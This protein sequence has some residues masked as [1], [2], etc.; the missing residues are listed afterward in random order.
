MKKKLFKKINIH[1]YFITYIIMSS[2]NKSLGKLR[3]FLAKHRVKS[4]VKHTNTSMGKLKGSYSIPDEKYEKF[5]DIYAEAILDGNILSLIEKHSI[6]SPIIIDLDFRHDYN[7]GETISREFTE[8]DIK[9][10][11]KLYYEEIRKIFIIDEPKQLI[12]CVFQRAKPYV[13]DT[14]KRDGVHIMFPYI[15]SEPNAQFYLRNN[16]LSNL[17]DELDGLKLKNNKFD[18]IDRCVIESNGWFLYRSTKPKLGPYEWVHTY[19]MNLMEIEKTELDFQGIS[20]MAKFFSIRR[21]KRSTKVNESVIE[22]ILKISKKKTE[23]KLIKKTNTLTNYN[24][25][26]I[27]EYINILAKERADSYTSWMEVGWALH[28]I[29]PNDIQLLNYWIEFS[30]KSKKF[31]NGECETEWTK[32]KIKDDG[33]TVASIYYWAK[34]DNTDEYKKIKHKDIHYWVQQSYNSTHYGVAKVLHVMFE[35]SFVCVHAKKNTWYEFKNHKWNISES[36]VGLRKKIPTDLTM[37][38]CRYIDYL[39]HILVEDDLTAEEREELEDRRDK[40]TQITTRL[41]NT[42]FKESVMKECSADLFHS[43]KFE[44]KLDE[45]PYLIGFNNGVYDL[46]THEFRD[47]KPDDFISMSTTNDYIP[48]D[49]SSKYYE[50]IFDF[51]KKIQPDPE[52]REYLLLELASTLEGVNKREKFRVWTGTGGNGKSKL[53]ELFLTTFG[54][55]CDKFNISLLTG[56]RAKSNGATPDIVDSKGKRFAYLEEPNEGAKINCGLMKEFT[57]GDR[58]K[59]RGLYKESTSFKPQFKMFLLCN[60]L[61]EVPAH[62]EGVWRRMEVI[63]FGSKFVDDPKEPNEFKKDE[64][65]SEKIKNWGETFM[66]ILL[67]YH[68]IYQEKGI[69]VPKAVKDATSDYKNDSDDQMQFFKDTIECTDDDKDIIKWKKLYE[70]YRLW[71]FGQ[72]VS[73]K[74]PE[75]TQ[76]KFKKYCKK[77]FNKKYIGT[78]GLKCHIITESNEF[79]AEEF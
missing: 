22:D 78:T 14:V 58:I 65:L 36:G 64:G 47:G 24:I 16:V 44:E 28:N 46:K 77:V 74:N 41:G 23:K 57:G 75:L 42:S 45:N 12:A 72:T 30:K 62:D 76:I 53:V 9:N 19:N 26:R 73:G 8:D 54:E 15:I 70:E 6:M 29:N 11:L 37:E 1:N 55:Y 13:K 49:K 38:Y 63:N 59:G 71:M 7:A 66:G 18:V 3:K 17:T 68:K 69:T 4:G 31:R 34:L 2:S 79:E 67:E 33:L 35:H 20:N 39:N 48:L 50:E 52:V 32:F 27:G 5:L 43:G 60:D 10:I 61:P 56:K 25:E 40:F 51:L 21:H